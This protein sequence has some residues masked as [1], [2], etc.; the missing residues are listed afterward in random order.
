MTVTSS[1][2]SAEYAGNSA[3]TSFTVPFRFLEDGHL[4][5]TLVDAD[6]TEHDQVLNTDYTVSGAG[7][8]TGDITFATAPASGQTIQIL[9][10]VPITQEK[11][12]VT[13]D[14]FPAES[15]ENAL[16]KLTMIAGQQRE[17]LDRAW[18][19]PVGVTGGRITKGAAGRVPKYDANGNLIPGP[20]GDEIENAQQY[21][22][23]AHGYRD[24]AEQ[25]VAD[26][27]QMIVP[28]GGVSF[29]KLGSDIAV[30]ADVTLTVGSG[31]NFSTINDALAAA[32]ILR[33]RPYVQGG[34]KVEIKLLSGFVMAEQVMIVDQDF[35]FITITA[36]DAEV[37]IDATALNTAFPFQIA[38]N[39]SGYPAFSGV[40]SVMPTI[41]CLFNMSGVGPGQGSGRIGII[42]YGNT[43]M[44]VL[45]GCGLKNSYVNVRL[46]SCSHLFAPDTIWS[47]G[48]R[49][50]VV[51]NDGSIVALTRTGITIDN[52]KGFGSDVSDCQGDA[53]LAHDSC[54]IDCRGVVV[55]N[56]AGS[57][58]HARRG[59][60]I[61]AAQ[62]IVDGA[63]EAGIRCDRSS[64]IYA[65]YVQAMH[66]A[67]AVICYRGSRV[68]LEGANL[69]Y[70]TN[71]AIDAW[72]NGNVNGGVASAFNAAKT[73]TIT[74]ASPAV[75]AVTAHN[76]AIGDV[77]RLTTTGALPTGLATA[78][79]YFI[80][81]IVDADHYKISAT[82]NGSAINTSGSQS[83]THTATPQSQPLLFSG[84]G[85]TGAYFRSSDGNL[86]GAY[87]DNCGG[88][89]VYAMDGSNVN[90]NGIHVNNCTAYGLRSEN[91]SDIN[92]FGAQAKNA[93]TIGVGARIGARI[94]ANGVNCSGA[95]T[96]GML[97]FEGSSI[98][99]RGANARMGGSDATTD[100]VV[101][102]G[103][104]INTYNAKTG[105][106]SQTVNTLTAD[107]IIFG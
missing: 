94:N 41:G 65:N 40:R 30:S 70:A 71:Y 79:D 9:R 20:E 29:S 28:N 72:Q 46:F 15:H 18:T 66:C 5:V 106:V 84:A 31:G 45:T 16:D 96:N 69:M 92:A 43:G 13:G 35:G 32:S 55:T 37:E 98:N 61:D 7:N 107:G 8:A 90:A 102:R 74:I 93:G 58:I 68:D 62:A 17:V 75:V 50:G 19:S 76:A 89:G 104:F 77:I 33:I 105:G 1:T 97:A 56:C 59:S 14:K 21:A 81:E 91:G 47:G 100:F 11:D 34:F 22:E 67:T 10:N 53:I 51:A 88:N 87:G 82:P 52:G 101:Q 2:N 6:G 83:G 95:A 48:Y 60:S 36:E 86:E 54:I 44:A 23:E 64:T 38:D 85:S 80:V 103:S 57:A 49:G 4:S 99:A 27:G 12:Y 3:S 63:G 42:L 25:I 24:E 73:A 78:T 26:A 39:Y